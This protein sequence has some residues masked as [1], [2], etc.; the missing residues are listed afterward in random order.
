M[1]YKFFLVN[2][3]E[4]TYEK[5]EDIRTLAKAMGWNL[6]FPDKIDP[7]GQVWW[8]EEHRKIGAFFEIVEE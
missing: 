8:P 6:T 1:A 2:G 3:F 7:I 4:K 5:E